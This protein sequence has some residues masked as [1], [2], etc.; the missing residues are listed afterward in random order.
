MLAKPLM[1]LY[2]R[3]IDK[4]EIPEDWKKANISPIFKKGDKSKVENYRPV[5]LTVFYGKVMEK[6]VKKNIESFLMDNKL[7]KNSQHGFMKGGSCLRNLLV[8]QDSIISTIDGG[9]PVDVIYLDFQK[10]FDKVPHRSEEHTSELQSRPHLVCRLLLE[11]KKK[12][13]TRYSITGQVSRKL[14]MGLEA[15][16]AYKYEVARHAT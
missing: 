3:S 13:E 5:S 8:C 4:N 15:M 6:I 12:Q 7:I 14:T 9:F 1:L 16:V 10:A 11:K 2:N